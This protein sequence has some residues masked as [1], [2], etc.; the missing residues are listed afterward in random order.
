[1]NDLELLDTYGPDAPPVSDAALNAA[2]ALL[3]DAMDP[4]T[5]PRRPFLAR[6]WGIALAGLGLA[7]AVAVAGITLPRTAGDPDSRDVAG[8]P[9]VT[10]TTGSGVIRLVAATEPE[11]PWTLPGLG[12]AVFTANPGE[13]IIAVYLAEDRSDVYL[14]GSDKPSGGE[15]VD[16]GGRAGRIIAFNGSTDGRSP[17]D[18]VWEHRP[19]RWLRLTGQGRY[20]TPEALVELAGRVQDEP[21]R[22]RFE[23][24]VGLIPDGWELA[25]FKDE[26]ILTYRDPAD[27]ETE[28]HVQWTPKSEPLFRAEEIEGLQKA[29]KATV[30][31]RPAD[32]FRTDEFWMAQARLP[33]GSSFRV[34]TPRSFTSEQ[35]LELAG[36]VRRT[37]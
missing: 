14:T 6:G 1:V 24:A 2:R 28:F 13:P 32:L 11:F 20:G 35:T 8:G 15:P 36:S 21:Q 5:P 30:A 10:A 18:L 16:V 3:L 22:V 26:S 37:A 7:A 17:L 25:A 19:G 33:D 23:V 34:M 12:E 31:G 9:Q 4:A 29:T 27:P